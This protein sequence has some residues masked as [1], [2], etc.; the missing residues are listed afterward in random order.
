MAT[1][2][3]LRAISESEKQELE[4]L[5]RSRT[6]PQGQVERAKIVLEW[7]A[8]ERTEAIAERVGCS[9]ATV[10]NQVNAFNARGMDFLDDVPRSGRP[11]TYNERQ[12]GEMVL[13]AETPPQQLDLPYDH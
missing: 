4:R 2:I 11:H 5:S 10:Y 9:T 6:A 7:L 12:R 8:G 1:W 3:K 13:A